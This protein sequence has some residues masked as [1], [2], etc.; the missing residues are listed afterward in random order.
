MLS[1]SKVESSV[2]VAVVRGS[3][4]A[5]CDGQILYLTDSMCA[6]HDSFQDIEVL[7]GQ[8]QPIPDP[9]TRLV[10]YLA[11]CSGSGKSTCASNLMAE[12]SQQNPKRPIFIISRVKEDSAFEGI[13]HIE[14]IDANAFLEDPL[15]V[16]SF[17]EVCM[18]LFDDIDCF[19][20]KKV[21][22]AVVALRQDIL[23]T[24]RHKKIA[25]IVTNHCL[26]A[27][28]ETKTILNESQ[29]TTIFPRGGSRNQLVYMLKNY[30]GMDK[31]EISHLMHLPSRWVSIYRPYP[32]CVIYS[33]G[34]YTS[35]GGANA[36]KV[37]PG[38]RVAAGSRV[39]SALIR[40]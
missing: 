7:D 2:P 23:E 14:R 31:H 32:S 6:P 10:A 37:A 30:Y 1:W 34:A 25:C 19:P 12:W 20:D 38:S 36:G 28:H 26:I 15:T 13:P 22:E 40:R 18:V 27:G 3:R 21:K 4:G 29:L 35:G 39:E 5:K 33:T 8:L 24:G 16:D 17:P 11:G 9:K